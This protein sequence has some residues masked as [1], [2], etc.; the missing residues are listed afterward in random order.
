VVERDVTLLP[1]TRMDGDSSF[2]ELVE[3]DTVNLKE[4]ISVR[5]RE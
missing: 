3:C 2:W 5:F 4:V 1:E